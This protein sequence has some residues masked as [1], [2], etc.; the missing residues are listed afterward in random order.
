MS[1][2]FVPS[3]RIHRTHLEVVGGKLALVDS[4]GL[5]SGGAC[6]DPF[7]SLGLLGESSPGHTGRGDG[8]VDVDVVPQETTDAWG[9][10]GD[11]GRALADR[12][13]GI[14]DKG[15]SVAVGL[16]NVE[17]GVDAED[18]GEADNGVGGDRILRQGTA[19]VGVGSLDGQ[20]LGGVSINKIR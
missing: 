6:A 10:D 13:D 2:S 17:T 19:K 14:G 7:G 16:T 12:D 18:V 11:L 5:E 20:A 1:Q 3:P 9:G 8:V 4:A 15:E